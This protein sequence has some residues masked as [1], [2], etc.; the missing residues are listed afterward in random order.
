MK[1][2][3]IAHIA[4]L[5]NL[6]YCQSLG[7]TSVPE[8]EVAGEA[9]I[10]SLV[11]GVEMH[12]ANP[13]ATPEQSHESW[14]AG[15][16]A[17]GWVYGEVKDAEAKTHHCIRPYDELPD[18]QKAKDYLFR[19]TVHAL[20]DI[21]DADEAVVLA[22]AECRKLFSE[23]EKGVTTPAAGFAPNIIGVK[24]IGRREFWKDTVYSSGLSFEREQV[25]GIPA[26][27]ARK[28]L[29][30]EDLFE[31]AEVT[32][33]EAAEGLAA[34][35]V[36]MIANAKANKEVKDKANLEFAIID[37]VNQMGKKELV[38][39]AEQRFGAKLDIKTTVAA[40]RNEITQRINQFGAL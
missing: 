29:R 19:G 23:T 22:V 21:P 18:S 15:K 17:D 30:H 27:I 5:I 14:L 38:E 7:D 1:V 11:A 32:A 35:A 33:G 12:L 20:K 34:D 40:L 8:W 3:A 24:Y 10:A 16:I 6:A 31:R 2:L 37:Q 36:D 4:H 39:F 25:R 13:D 28:L 26:E 9:H